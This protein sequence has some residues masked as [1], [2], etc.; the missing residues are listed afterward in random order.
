MQ[1]MPGDQ[2]F[3]AEMVTSLTDVLPSARN[4][5]FLFPLGRESST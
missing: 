4:G 3:A 5:Q 2:A 1:L